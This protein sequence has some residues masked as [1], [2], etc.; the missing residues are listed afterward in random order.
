MDYADFKKTNKK[1]TEEKILAELEHWLNEGKWEG[2]GHLH[3]HYQKL[4]DAIYN[5]MCFE[6]A[7]KKLG[8]N[9]KEYAIVEKDLGE[10]ETIEELK[11]WV[12]EDRWEGMQH[13]RNHHIYLYK[14][15]KEIGVEEAFKRIGLDYTYQDK[16]V[17]WTNEKII[18][19]F[20]RYVEEHGWGGTLKF[21]E[22]A[23]ILRSVLYKRMSIEKA[24]ELIGL[25]YEAYR[26]NEQWN[27]EKML[28]ALKQWIDS[29]NWNGTGHFAENKGKLY[30]S[31][32]KS[33]G[34]EEAFE[35]LGLNF[36]VDKLQ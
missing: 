6:V 5:Y 28:A 14:G 10:E 17:K 4:Y 13:L 22:E 19:D 27:E 24:F 7:F 26:V 29:G 20:K 1:W 12:E 36:S 21:K 32:Y 18:N 15:L 8:L 2:S 30:K 11:K 25:D 35:K 16:S 34:M 3:K 31:I 23:P 9:Y 33:F